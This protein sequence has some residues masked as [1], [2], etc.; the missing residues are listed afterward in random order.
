MTVKEVDKN[1]VKHVAIEFVRDFSGPCFGAHGKRMAQN[2]VGDE[3]IL[4]Q[5]TSSLAAA[6]GI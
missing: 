3:D 6:F 4:L 1:Q 5:N 2:A